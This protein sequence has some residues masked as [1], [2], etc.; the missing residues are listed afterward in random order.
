MNKLEIKN[1]SKS[2]GGF[3]LYKVSFEVK[4]GS[5]VGLIGENGAG[6]S[7]VIKSVLGVIRPDGGEIYLDGHNLNDNPA[8]RKKLG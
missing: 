2:Y 8:F 5:A 6:K 1:L 4:A 7:T 3:C